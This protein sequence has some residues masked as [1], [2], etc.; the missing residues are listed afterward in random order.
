MNS[1]DLGS[2]YEGGHGLKKQPPSTPDT[3]FSPA[4]LANVLD[5]YGQ[6]AVGLQYPWWPSC[7]EH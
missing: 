5:A 1:P 7:S 6:V 2:S 4:C 3:R